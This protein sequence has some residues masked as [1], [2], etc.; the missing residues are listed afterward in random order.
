MT[1]FSCKC[2]LE[3][4]KSP[5][6]KHSVHYTVMTEAIHAKLIQDEDSF[7]PKYN[8]ASV[9]NRIPTFRDDVVFSSSRADSS[10]IEKSDLITD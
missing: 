4:V 8:P 2:L 7:Y 1:P 3:I 9:Y 10:R 6:K 5:L